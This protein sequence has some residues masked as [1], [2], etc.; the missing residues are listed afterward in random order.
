MRGLTASGGAIR[1]VL[2]RHGETPSNLA[3]VLDTVPPGPGLTDA[4]LAQAEA[5]AE[6]FGEEKLV[7]LHASRALRAQQTAA[8]LAEQVGLDVAV[9]DDLHEIYVGDLEGRGDDE[10]RAIFDATYSSWHHGRLDERLPGGE[11]GREALDR[12]C[13]AAQRI[14]DAAT[15]GV[16]V[17]VSH[18]AMLRLVANLLVDEVDGARADASYL[19][20]T[21]AIALD[22]ALD[23]PTG[24]RCHTWD[25]LA[26]P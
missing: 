8:P 22:A 21:G 25:G 12:F 19:P 23:A 15:D 6:R 16:V 24:W 20:N 5:L 2:A 26:P 14:V 7:A 1:L 4:G 10:S 3:R 17:I 13:G 11:T 9:A 18:G